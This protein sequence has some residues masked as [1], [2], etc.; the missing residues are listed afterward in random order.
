MKPLWIA[1]GETLDDEEENER[2]SDLYHDDLAFIT[3]TPCRTRAGLLAK[4][5]ALQ[6]DMPKAFEGTEVCSTASKSERLA[7]SLAEDVL[8]LAK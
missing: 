3:D 8:A 5:K 1:L 7:W 4:A 6:L 2:I